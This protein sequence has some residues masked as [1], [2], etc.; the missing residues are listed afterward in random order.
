MNYLDIGQ[1]LW[2]LKI[3]PVSPSINIPENISIQEFF[4]LLKHELDIEEKESY[5]IMLRDKEEKRNKRYTKDI[6]VK[7]ITKNVYNFAYAD[8]NHLCRSN[9]CLYEEI[10]LPDDFIEDLFRN[11]VATY[12][13][14]LAR[15]YKLSNTDQKKGLIWSIWIAKKIRNNR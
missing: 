1:D 2:L 12:K 5:F 15:D 8:S 11:H 7:D 3:F 13:V 14:N 9:I 6:L 10:N 4:E